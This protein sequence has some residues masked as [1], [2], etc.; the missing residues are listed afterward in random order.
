[1]LDAGLRDGTVDQEQKNWELLAYYYQQVDKQNKA[2]DILKLA[3]SRF[4]KTGLLDFQAAQIYY[5]ID[6]L[7][8][9]YSEARLA[10]TKNLGDK[11]A[12]VWQ[13][14]AYCAFE[15]RK[16]S[17]ALEAVDNAIAAEKVKGGKKDASLPRLKQAIE[18]S[19]K[20]RDAS[21]EALKAKQ[22]L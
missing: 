17:E 1:M 16:Y 22:K 12:P 8:D 14:V 10:T 13:F 3:S 7:D 19:I 2:I 4:P 18:E 21:A 5:S 20:E 9:A 6:K 15:Q 11:G